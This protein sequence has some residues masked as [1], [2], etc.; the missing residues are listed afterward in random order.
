M[1]RADLPAPWRRGRLRV[2]GVIR[3]FLR[4]VL[5]V[6]ATVFVLSPVAAFAQSDGGTGVYPTTPTTPTTEVPD[7]VVTRAVDPDA[8]P[9][10]FTG[11]DAALLAV[12]G[13]AAVVSGGAILVFTRRRSSTSSP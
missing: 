9:L 3:Q 8:T 7:T 2:S 12:L 6:S 13:V 11:G 4:L 1:I 10:P 5:L